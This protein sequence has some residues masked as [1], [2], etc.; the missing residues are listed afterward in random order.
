[1]RTQLADGGA[2][3]GSQGL[4]VEDDER[5]EEQRERKSDG[6]ETVKRPMASASFLTGSTG[7]LPRF[8]TEGA[9]VGHGDEGGLGSGVVV[10]D[11]EL[12]S[13]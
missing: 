2:K 1:M 13:G 5:K 9:G 8:L 7:G 12:L 10:E 11:V 4:L 3:V 6:G